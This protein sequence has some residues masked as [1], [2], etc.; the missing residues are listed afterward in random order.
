VASQA[1]TAGLNK[2]GG[3][4]RSFGGMMSKAVMPLSMIAPGLGMAAALGPVGLVGVGLGMAASEGMRFEQQMSAVRAV[5]GASGPV[6][7]KLTAQ[8]KQFGLEGQ[9]SATEVAAAM[10]SLGQAGYNATQIAGALAGSLNL[11]AA[12][13]MEL[14][15]ATEMVVNILSQ[16]G[17]KANQA[18]VVADVLAKGAAMSTV[19]V[20]DLGESLKFVGTQASTAGMNIQQTTALLAALADKGLKAEMGG[21]GLRGIL[22]KMASPTKEAEAE[23]KRLG[24]SFLD[25]NGNIKPTA[26]FVGEFNKAVKGMPSGEKLRTI[27]TMF[28]T[29]SGT[30]FNALLKTGVE[31]IA[32]YEA[33]VNEAGGSSKEMAEMQADNV[34]GAWKRLRNAVGLI[35]IEIFEG[36]M[37]GP[38]KAILNALGGL[39]RFVAQH[40]GALVQAF[41]L[42]GSI[43]GALGASLRGI[44]QAFID[45]FGGGQTTM[46][47]F[48]NFVRP[49]WAAFRDMMLQGMEVIR[50]VFFNAFRA[51]FVVIKDF[52]EALGLAG[53]TSDDV[54][55]T[56][57]TALNVIEFALKNFELIAEMAL[58][59]WQITFVKVFEDLRHWLT[60]ILPVLLPWFAEQFRSAFVQIAN[61]LKIMLGGTVANMGRVMANLPALAAGT[62]S[63]TDVWEP[64]GEGLKFEL[65]GLPAI[66]DRWLTPL[67]M[68]LRARAEALNKAFNGK[69]ADFK[70]DKFKQGVKENLADPL[71]AWA[72][73]ILPKVADEADHWRNKLGMWGMILAGA[74]EA[75]APSEKM[76]G[77]FEEGSKEALSTIAK[78]SR[79]AGLDPQKEMVNQQK[80]GNKLLGGMK[81]LLGDIKAGIDKLEPAAAL[82]F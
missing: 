58:V 52:G 45:V 79:T 69:W 20:V 75:S 28:E 7:A 17:M 24:L 25:A 34:L 30:A 13:G 68:Q 78:Y 16:F 9:F 56:I 21:T 5:T 2:A 81:Q 10:V 27:G 51:I 31:G 64:I 41:I 44:S 33:K 1:L 70:D 23:M 6:M 47:D 76:A 3:M 39:F 65:Q 4:V 15:Q 53:T 43:W 71:M 66:A 72:K 74:A 77:A 62:K 54:K 42:A 57:V 8:A 82:D 29:R 11:A 61:N 26:Q 36:G 32:A 12:G 59:G 67:E 40:S 48:V 46:K 18:G 49:I 37:A 80:E 50:V 73:D 63:L 19:S 22:T 60:S 38:I 14:S 55:G 35:Q